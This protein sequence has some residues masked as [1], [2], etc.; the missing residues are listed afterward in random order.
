VVPLSLHPRLYAVTHSA[1]FQS[2][3]AMDVIADCITSFRDSV[4]ATI[5]SGRLT[6]TTFNEL[7]SSGQS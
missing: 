7:R 5:G 6:S 4:A 2:H 1:G 3:E